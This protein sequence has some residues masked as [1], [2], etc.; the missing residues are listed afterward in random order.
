M[1]SPNDD[2][3]WD[4]WARW[5]SGGSDAGAG[6]W[7]VDTMGWM[8]N[9]TIPTIDSVHVDEL[10]SERVAR[11]LERGVWPQAVERIVRKSENRTPW[12]FCYLHGFGA[13]RGSGE[14]VMQNLAARYGAN[15]FFARLPGHGHTAEQHAKA[16]AESYLERA[17]WTLSVARA[18][19]HRVCIVGSSTGGLLAT[20]LAAR[21]PELVDAIIL[22]SPFYDYR[23]PTVRFLSLPFGVDAIEWAYGS[24]R[25][26]RYESERVQPGY[27]DHWLLDQRTRALAAAE[28]LRGWISRDDVYQRVQSPT[29]LLYYPGDETVSVDAMHRAFAKIGSHPLSRFHPIEDGDHVLL[30]EFVRTDKAAIIHAIDGFLHDLDCPKAGD[31]SSE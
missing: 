5:L 4:D 9:T 17:A 31:R 13:T 11:D 22:A 18:L 20:W 6:Q 16:A 7:L 8:P 1:T 23:D 27:E 14:H 25:D 2:S 29:L 19:G 30:S 24:E 21:W 10:V 15:T 28:R 26:T 3:T 12:S